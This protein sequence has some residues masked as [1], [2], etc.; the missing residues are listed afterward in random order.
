MERA[1]LEDLTAEVAADPGC[2]AFSVLAELLRR[3]GR[4]EDARRV[5]E[6]GLEVRPSYL[7][8]RVVHGLALMDLG[9]LEAARKTLSAALPGAAAAPVEDLSPL[10]LAAVDEP[11]P[12]DAAAP[13]SGRALDAPDSPFHEPDDLEIHQAFEGA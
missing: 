10:E 9:E 7:E 12:W 11:S 8:G 3:A 5:A 2:D 6:A 1:E 13:D 4:C